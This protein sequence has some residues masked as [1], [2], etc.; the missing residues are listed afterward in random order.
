MNFNN[1]KLVNWCIRRYFRSIPIPKD[2]LQAAGLLHLLRAIREFDPELEN[3]FSTFAVHVIKNG[4]KREFDELYHVSWENYIQ[5]LKIKELREQ[6]I[7]L[8]PSKTTI[9]ARELSDSGLTPHS[10]LSIEKYDELPEHIYL[11]SEIYPEPEP[12]AYRPARRHLGYR[13]EW[14]CFQIQSNTGQVRSC[15][16][17]CRQPENNTKTSSYIYRDRPQQPTLV[18]H[19]QRAIHLLHA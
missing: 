9:S 10:S 19:T 14:I 4:I 13:Q 15:D 2:E 8:D 3:Q 17:F 1:I 5:K 18:M 11:M 16:E 6:L 12:T 7:E